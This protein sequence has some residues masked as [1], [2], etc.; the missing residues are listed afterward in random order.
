MKH[1]RLFLILLYMAFIY[2]VVMAE[3]HYAK[4]HPLVDTPKV[5]KR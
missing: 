4:N 3:I 1:K 2:C 5:Q